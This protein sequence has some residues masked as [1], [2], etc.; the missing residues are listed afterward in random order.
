M[1][2]FSNLIKIYLDSFMCI[3]VLF[4]CIY[5]YHVCALSPPKPEEGVAYSRTAVKDGCHVNAGN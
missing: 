3:T 1:Y 5:M 4:A 2:V